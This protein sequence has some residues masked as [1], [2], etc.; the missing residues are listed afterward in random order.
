MLSSKSFMKF[1]FT[2]HESI[3]KTYT[4]P[5]KMNF[6]KNEI[7][8]EYIKVILTLFLLFTKIIIIII[9]HYAN[10]QIIKLLIDIINRY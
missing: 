8:T 1:E 2:Q 6:D 4:Q 9:N 5:I 7:A 3:C 10:F